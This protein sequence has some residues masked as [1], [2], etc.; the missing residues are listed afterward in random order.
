MM[1]NG[2]RMR[3][4]TKELEFNITRPKGSHIGI[5]KLKGKVMDK[6]MA[7]SKKWMS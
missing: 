7:T 3:W 1:N 6:E 5:W 2:R 4:S